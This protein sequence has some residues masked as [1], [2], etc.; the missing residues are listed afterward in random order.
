MLSDKNII[1]CNEYLTDYNGS[2][3]YIAAGYSE[4]GAR[5]NAS[6]LLQDLEIKEYIAKEIDKRGKR[7]KFTADD[8][9]NELV[10]IATDDLSNYLD[11]DE[12]EVL[13]TD[14]EG[15]EYKETIVNVS[16]K[17]SRNIP[18]K[19]IKSV[20]RGKDGQ[21]KFELYSREGAL[22]KLGKIHAMFIDKLGIKNE[23]E[24]DFSAFTPAELTAYLELM[25]KAVKK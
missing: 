5:N 13:R 10:S 6:V 20:T 2:R 18:T 16:I 25:K 21:F 3:A 8:V 11:F 14:K 24:V 7:L 17:D 15:N 4:S 1:F 9:F 22:E 23:N 12:R 19:N